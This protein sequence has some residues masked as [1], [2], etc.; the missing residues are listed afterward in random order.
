[1]PLQ[2]RV[3][4]FGEIVSNPARGRFMGNRGCIHDDQKQLLDRRWARPAWVTCTLVSK[5][6]KKWPLMVP[7][8]YTELF[9]T[10]EATSFAA[11]HRPC[12]QCRY[13][14]YTRF[15]Q[16]FGSAFPELGERP[17]ASSMD[18]ALHASRIDRYSR[19]QIT[20]EARLHDLPVGTFFVSDDGQRPVQV[21]PHGYGEWSF[22]GYHA[23]KIDGDR[24]VT[25]LTPFPAV[26]A[27]KAGYL[28][29]Q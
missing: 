15:Q 3:T 20:F 18:A 23:L 12:R 6:G 24:T 17:S 7:G 9:F 4:P 26:Q 13:D 5:T 14:A 16:A 10:D 21:F 2:N 11:G 25:V 28:V 19:K 29:E 22:E 27:F 8:K 1:M